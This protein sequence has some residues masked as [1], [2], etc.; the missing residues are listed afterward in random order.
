LNG[1]KGER[2]VREREAKALMNVTDPKKKGPGPDE[3]E[4]SKRRKK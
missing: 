3:Q 4:E 2:S 1:E